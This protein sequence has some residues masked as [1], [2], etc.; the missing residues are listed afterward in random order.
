[1]ALFAFHAPVCTRETLPSAG[2]IVQGTESYLQIHSYDL[3]R[4]D[5]LELEEKLFGRNHSHAPPL[6]LGLATRAWGGGELDWLGFLSGMFCVALSLLFLLS[7]FGLFPLSPPWFLLSD[8][9]LPRR[10]T[11]QGFPKGGKTIPQK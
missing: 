9:L 4:P 1:M 10:L 5:P 7:F 2:R 3:A 6:E 8:S 11:Q